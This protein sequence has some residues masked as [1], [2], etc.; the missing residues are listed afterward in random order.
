MPSRILTQLTALAARAA[1]RSRDER[2]SILLEALASAVLLAVVALAVLSAV[3]GA[4]AAS[5]RNEARSVAATLAEQDQER[6]RAMRFTDLVNLNDSNNVTVDGIVF[7][8]ASRADWIRDATG[9]TESC[10][11]DAAQADYLRI[12][13]TV[14]SNVVGTQT[15]PVSLTSLVT[16]NVSTFSGNEGALAVKV[17]DRDDQPV[18]GTNVTITSP[19]RTASDVTNGVGCAIFAHIPEGDYDITF[20]QTGWVTAKT[21]N[22]GKVTA[23]ETTVVEVRYDRAASVAVTYKTRWP[24]ATGDQRSR[25]FDLSANNAGLAGTPVT[26]TAPAPPVETLTVK[27]LFPYKTGYSFYSGTCQGPL[28]D[29]SNDPTKH[30]ASF[31]TANPSLGF[32]ALDPGDAKT[33]NV[34]Q[35]GVRA[36]VTKGGIGQTPAKVVVR[37]TSTGCTVAIPGMT[38]VADPATGSAGWLSKPSVTGIAYDPGLPFGHYTVCVQLTNGQTKKFDVPNTS[39]SGVTANLTMDSGTGIAPCT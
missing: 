8:V 10:T 30:D 37:S 11:S 1:A 3:D 7:K 15:A 16:P 31:Y 18:T 5:G 33:I 2:G 23:G 13:S 38:T 27:D 17:L 32:V 25:G 24:G 6:M 22:S 21:T 28:D 39:A 9:A 19:S 4:T 35:P 12:R 36:Q 20:N 34:L 14:T 26:A 29:Q